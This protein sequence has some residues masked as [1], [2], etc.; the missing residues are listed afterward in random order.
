MKTGGRT[1]LITGEMNQCLK[2]VIGVRENWKTRHGVH[3]GA[4]LKRRMTTK[5]RKMSGKYY[6]LR[7]DV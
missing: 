1:E 7:G 3:R 5:Y 2:P 4:G 6:Q